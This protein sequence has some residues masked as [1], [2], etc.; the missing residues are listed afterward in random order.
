[1]RRPPVGSRRGVR[2]GYTLDAETAR[3]LE[4]LAEATRR[5]KTAVIETAIE[6]LYRRWKAQPMDLT[7]S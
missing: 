7:P 2:T 1:M 5:S 4:E 6:E 3:Q